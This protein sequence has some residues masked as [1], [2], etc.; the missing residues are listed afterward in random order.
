MNNAIYNNPTKVLFGKGMEN[1]LGA[2]LKGKASRALLHYGSERVRESGLLKRVRASLESAGITCFEL[3]GVKGNPFLSLVYKGID[4]C[5]ENN[6]DLVVGV[7]G[8]SVID[9]AKAIAC[10]APNGQ[11]DV[12]AYYTGRG[13]LVA[14]KILPV[15]TVLTIPGAGSESSTGSV[16]T[17]EKTQEK[18]DYNDE[19]LRPV[20]SVL[21]PELTYTIP[22]YHT[23]AGVADA[24]AHV[25]E[26]YFTHTAYVDTTDRMCE[27]VIRTLI[28][29][30]KRVLGEPENYDV[31]AEVMWACKVAHDGTL[32]VGR[33]EEWT[34]HMIEHELS[35]KYDVSHGAGLA[36]IYPAWMQ[37]V[38]PAG[39]ERF[40]QF[41]MRV[42][43]VEYDFADVDNTVRKGIARLKHFFKSI[44]MPVSLKEL[45][46]KDDGDIEDMVKRYTAHN[47]EKTGAFMELT[48]A[49]IEKI[50]KSA[51]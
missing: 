8:G 5:R 44:G 16:V 15:A 17:N 28:K 36:V 27:G 3:G 10:G 39:K 40:A 11:N 6:V 47:G 21:N 30:G 34:S 14:E 2:A 32:G 50:L 48:A 22:V 26:R 29:Y 43:D 12:W 45:G 13:A 24:I 25:M 19:R 42:F 18:L 38:Y 51:L 4:V 9:S 37:M 20:V 41:A 46:V 49:D 35:A 1:E 23:A 31:R 7:G 33:Q